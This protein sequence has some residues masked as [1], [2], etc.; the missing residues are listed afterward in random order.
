MSGCNGIAMEQLLQFN[1][2]ETKQ[3]RTT[4]GDFWQK[5]KKNGTHKKKKV[6]RGVIFTV[7]HAQ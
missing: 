5:K 3:G 2:A 1:V 4:P 6:K 7:K